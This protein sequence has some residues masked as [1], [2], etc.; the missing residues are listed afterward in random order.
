MQFQVELGV[1]KVLL[2]RFPHKRERACVSVLE[3]RIVLRIGD[4]S[5]VTNIGE[6]ISWILYDGGDAVLAYYSL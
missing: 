4:T 1:D 6:N 2:S 5:Q 3:W